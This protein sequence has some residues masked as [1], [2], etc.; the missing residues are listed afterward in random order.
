MESFDIMIDY[1]GGQNWFQHGFSLYIAEIRWFL[2]FSLSK[3]ELKTTK[4]NF[5]I[6]IKLQKYWG[7]K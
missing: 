7:T 3:Q 1:F 2:F 4:M 5:Y 6:K